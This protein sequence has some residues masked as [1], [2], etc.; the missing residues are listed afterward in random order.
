MN[1]LLAARA[2]WEHVAAMTP[3][4]TA[5]ERSPDRGRGLAR[6]MRVR[7][8]LEEVGQPYEVRLLSFTEMKESAHRV[9]HPFEQ[10]PTYEEGDL[11]LF[12]SGAIVFHIA[13]RH[14]GLL[15]DDASARARAITWM[16]AALNT[17][18]PPIVERGMATLVER[19]KTWYEERQPIL[20]D[21]VRKRLGQLSVRLGDADWL[22]NAFSAGDLLMVTVLRRL[23]GSG[24]LEK[25]PNLCAYVARGEARPAV[26]R[27]VLVH[28]TQ[29]EGI[30]AIRP[31]ARR[32]DH[33]QHKSIKRLGQIEPIV[34]A[35][36][37]IDRLVEFDSP[38]PG[39]GDGDED[40]DKQAKR[41]EWRQEPDKDGGAGAELDQRH[42][43][44]IEAQCWNAERLE[45]IDDRAVTLCIEQLVI[46]RQHEKRPDRDAV[47][48]HREV[49][50][51]DANE[52]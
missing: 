22:D 40:D 13:E 32:D 15:P 45:F 38:S 46:S 50:P 52:Q 5:F 28:Q 19:D 51:P 49:G 23:N 34:D 11:A 39:R 44:L 12:E 20:E 37:F 8:A 48:G 27:G 43:P 17:V 16:F 21:R 4:I 10:I 3:I 29:D 36:R 26:S 18:E 25:Y 2:V 7:W 1:I 33:D 30:E 6:D 35:I 47:Q 14:A 9:L 42:P 24:L 41:G 31:G